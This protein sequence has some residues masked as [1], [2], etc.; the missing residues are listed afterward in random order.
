ML[1]IL[2]NLNNPYKYFLVILAAL[3]LLSCGRESVIPE[4]SQFAVTIYPLASIMREIAGD[5]ASVST[6]IPPGTSMH[7]FSPRPSDIENLEKSAGIVYV[8]ENLEGWIAHSNSVKKFRAFDFV[9]DSSVIHSVD[10]HNHGH[11]DGTG[12]DPHF[13]TDPLLVKKL[14]PKLTK[15]MIEQNPEDSLKYLKNSSVLI[16]KLDSLHIEFRDKFSSFRGKSV[17]LYHPSF[18]YF[19]KRY[20]LKYAGSVEESPGKEPSFRHL[21]ELRKK[22]K[23]L[24]LKIV[25]AEPQLPDRTIRVLS[26]GLDI[27]VL[28][29]DPIGGGDP[30]RNDY[31]K[32]MRFNAKNLL[33]SLR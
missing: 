8:A 21:A 13:W 28:Y 7:V 30:G 3:S 22:I 33:K 12:I 17:M 25:Y 26:E 11:S 18:L 23:K 5:S 4:K 9:P 1:L 24:N 16:E 6:V 2:M 20:G 14:V 29:L 19:F 32:L 31:F 15:W 10:E 27:L